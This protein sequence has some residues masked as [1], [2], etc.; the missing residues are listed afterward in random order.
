MKCPP[1]LFRFPLWR[2]TRI[3][4]NEFKENSGA[5]VTMDARSPQARGRGTV[6]VVGTAAIESV[7]AEICR[8]AA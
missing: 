5:N 8:C 1:A 3:E 2:E 4:E 6:R 7:D